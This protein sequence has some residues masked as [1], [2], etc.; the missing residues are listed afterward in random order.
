MI[1]YQGDWI[2]DFRLEEITRETNFNPDEVNFT[3]ISDS[4][5]S[6]GV[7]QSDSAEQSIA[8]TVPFRPDV[9]EVIEHIK[10]YWPIGMCLPDGSS[11]LIPN[12]G[13]AQVQDNGL[14]DLDVDPNKTLVASS[15]ST[16]F[17]A[18][19]Y[20][21]LA[22]ESYAL[23]HGYFTQAFLDIVQSCPFRISHNDLMDKLVT[24]VGE[25]SGNS[26]TP[27]LRGKLGRANNIFLEGWNESI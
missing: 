26:Q 16:L 24:R 18:C 6:G 11:E 12:V 19:K 7:H 23:Q 4:C 5:H 20:Y 17:A 10:T 1:P 3:M 25:L 2:H 9:A 8:R 21:E 22:R 14:I 15:K 27:Q 13:H